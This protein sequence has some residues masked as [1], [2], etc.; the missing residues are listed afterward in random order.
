MPP[1]HAIEKLHLPHL[2]TTSSCRTS[3]GGGSDE[4]ASRLAENDAALK[5]GLAEEASRNIICHTVVLEALRNVERASAAEE[6]AHAQA[7]LREE[8]RVNKMLMDAD[9]YNTSLLNAA[10]ERAV[11]LEARVT[12]LATA[13]ATAAAELAAAEERTKQAEARCNSAYAGARRR[14]AQVEREM[15][16]DSNENALSSNRLAYE[17][18]A[19]RRSMAKLMGKI[20]CQREESEKQDTACKSQVAAL[21]SVCKEATDRTVAAEACAVRL[22][23]AYEACEQQRTYLQ[24]ELS[25]VLQ[26]GLGNAKLAMDL[27]G[28][29]DLAESL[30]HAI[31]VAVGVPLVEVVGGLKPTVCTPLVKELVPLVQTV[32]A[33]SGDW[34]AELMRSCAVEGRMALQKLQQQQ[35]EGGCV[36]SEIECY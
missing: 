26:Q 32:M 8:K 7:Q 3:L 25:S 30:V 36:A 19:A 22:A 21:R 10:N 29:L 35:L 15:K 18:A 31:L 17:L 12:T 2:R 33:R 4:E 34:G 28:R 27:A 11:E 6:L 20:Q 23:A 1:C 5:E 9:V 16:R 13:V 14:V 24:S